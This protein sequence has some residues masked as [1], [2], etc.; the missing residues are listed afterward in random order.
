MIPTALAFQATTKLAR[1]TILLAQ[2]TGAELDIG[3]NTDKSPDSVLELFSNTSHSRHLAPR[4]YDYNVCSGTLPTDDFKSNSLSE[5][6]HFVANIAPVFVSLSPN[7]AAFM[8]SWIS[9]VTSVLISFTQL[10][11]ALRAMNSRR[12]TKL[13]WK[14][15]A[16]NIGATTVA[17]FRTVWVTIKIV[18]HRNSLR[19]LPFLSP[20][21]WLDWVLVT[22]LLWTR[23]PILGW[24]GFGFTVALWVLCLWLVIGYTALDYGAEQYQVLNVPDQ[25]RYLG[26]PWQ[27]DPRRKG[28][29]SL[30]ICLFI[31]SSVAV[32]IGVYV[33]LRRR[34]RPEWDAYREQFGD[35]QYYEERRKSFVRAIGLVLAMAIGGVN[36]AGAV[37]A[38][39]LN[40]SDYL[41]LQRDGCFASYVSSRLGYFETDAVNAYIKV[42]EFL[43][44]LV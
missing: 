15:K 1:R 7:T 21:L 33:Y 2:P 12:S 22:D 29:L 36:C 27:T 39:I 31:F 43:G 30:H 6:C 20:V 24:L 9:Y 10:G 28:F 4:S 5:V 44:I 3:L 32:C 42:A 18:N 13:D 40:L 17:I 11:I 37:W 35:Q 38:G 8:P 41:I 19:T 16:R 23:V 26:V 34:P 14:L 25:C